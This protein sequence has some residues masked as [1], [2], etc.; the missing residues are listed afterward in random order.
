MYVGIVTIYY[1]ANA[2]SAVPNETGVTDHY[3]VGTMYKLFL[4]DNIKY[5]YMFT[6]RLNFT[7]LVCLTNVF[8]FLFVRV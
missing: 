6:I 7:V 4:A 8:G 5:Y 1:T 3:L 2:A